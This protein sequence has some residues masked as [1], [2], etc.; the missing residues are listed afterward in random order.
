[1]KKNK[2]ILIVVI[3][4][5]IVAV[6]LILQNRKTTLNE[7]MGE[8]AI[9]DTSSVTKIFMADMRG[10]QVLLSKSAPGK[11]LLD[12]SL[13]A[14]NESL[15]LLLKTMSNIAVKAPVPKKSYNSVI[16]RLATNSIKVE[17][18][19]DKFRI[20]LFNFIRLF[21][22]EKLSKVYYVGNPTPDN[23]GT[24]MLLEGSEV[25]F[26]VYEPGFRGFIAARYTAHPNDWRDHTVFKTKAD[27]VKSI[28]IEFPYEPNESY[29]IEKQGTSELNLISLENKQKLSSFDTRRL[30]DLVK[31]YKDIRFE[32][33]LDAIEPARVDSIIHTIPLNIITLTDTDGNVNQVKTYRRVTATGDFDLE[34]NR[35]TYDLDRL[36][37]LINNGQ[38]LVLIQYFVFDPITRPLSFLV[39][40]EIV[41]DS[42]PSNRY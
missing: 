15:N 33:V 23:L 39:G 32:A 4:L 8:F 13:K 30:V 40:R 11:W 22:H 10:N 6:V 20:D 2:G 41:E 35:V 36:Y 12:D 14:G 37:A 18:Y 27:K 3:V 21:P 19:Q 7:R 5:A 28:Q 34:G 17:I 29:L 42:K 31:L 16:K 24:F 25:P 26:V 9:A 38:E 1:M